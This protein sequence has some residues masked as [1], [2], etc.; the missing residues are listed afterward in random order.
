MS[1][2]LGDYRKSKVHFAKNMAKNYFKQEFWRDK[3]SKTFLNHHS[4]DK[5]SDRDILK[6]YRIKTS[7]GFRAFSRAS[8]PVEQKST[9]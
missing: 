6:S 2:F 3:T 4:K 5:I 7:M 9:Y 1:E 8:P